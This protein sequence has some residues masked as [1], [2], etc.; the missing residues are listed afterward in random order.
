MDNTYQMKQSASPA[1]PSLL[2][3]YAGDIDANIDT[4]LNGDLD[5]DC[6]FSTDMGIK[7]N[8]IREKYEQAMKRYKDDTHPSQA[9]CDVAN[10]IQPNGCY[11]TSP[12]KVCE[13]PLDSKVCHD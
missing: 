1:S 9:Q 3:T 7:C 8:L 6:V 4:D 12:T 5:P 10:Y 13:T 2:E 11:K